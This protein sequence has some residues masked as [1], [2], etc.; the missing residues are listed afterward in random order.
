MVLSSVVGLGY[1]GITINIANSDGLSKAPRPL[2]TQLAQDPRV[3]EA[4]E[5]SIDRKVLNDVI[6]NGEFLPNCLPIP[7]LS[8]FYP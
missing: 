1:Q 4:L 7:T 6:N 5:V 2:T 3:R 8:V